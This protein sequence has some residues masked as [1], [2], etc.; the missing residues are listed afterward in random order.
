[1]SIIFIPSKKIYNIDYKKISNNVVTKVE[2]SYNEIVK[3]FGNVLS[4]EYNLRFLDID[5]SVDISA[6][7]LYENPA[8]NYGFQ[9]DLVTDSGDAKLTSTLALPIDKITS[10]IMETN[11][12][13]ETILTSHKLKSIRRISQDNGTTFREQ[14]ELKAPIVL[15]YNKSSKIIYLKYEVVLQRNYEITFSDT[16]S[17]VGEYI[18]TN[19]QTQQIGEGNHAFQ[20]QSN[21]LIQSENTNL[22]RYANDIIE[23]YIKGKETA[24]VLCSIGDYTDENEKLVISTNTADKMIFE[25]YD[26]VLPMVRNSWGTD[27]PLSL[28]A[29]GL[30]KVFEVVGV[31]IYADGAVW[32]ELTMREKGEIAVQLQLP[33]PHLQLNGSVLTITDISTV[34]ERYY[35]YVNGNLKASFSKVNQYELSNLNLSYGTYKITLI[36]SANGYKDSEKSRPVKYV[37]MQEF[38]TT[39]YTEVNSANGLSYFITS[40]DYTVANGTYII[41]D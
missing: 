25:H 17:L 34:A 40:N 28:N 24:T 3:E 13:G 27:T 26:K 1:M 33:A 16:I 22:F 18:T 8:Y 31:R 15:N 10:F 39:Y 29:N 7:V 5:P 41:G 20:I 19:E 35:L 21:D 11:A 2:Q 6:T 36:A 32:Q 14:T 30:A 38:Y 37:F 9:F 4:T 23:H 12:N